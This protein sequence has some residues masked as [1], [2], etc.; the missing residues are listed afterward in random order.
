VTRNARLLRLYELRRYVI[1]RRT[2]DGPVV[3]A[4]V[5]SMAE[6]VVVAALE[7]VELGKVLLQAER[8]FGGRVARHIAAC[9]GCRTRVG[10]AVKRAVAITRGTYTVEAVS[11]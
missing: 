3:I 6:N 4:A 1:S 11:A 5:P 9:D 7:R 8:E 2:P 10:A